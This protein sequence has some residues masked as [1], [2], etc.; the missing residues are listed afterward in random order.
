MRGVSE[1]QVHVHHPA[2]VL[3]TLFILMCRAGQVSRLHW[4]PVP[5]SL[6]GQLASLKRAGVPGLSSVK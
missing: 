4:F 6:D 2:L 3:G 1:P 5:A